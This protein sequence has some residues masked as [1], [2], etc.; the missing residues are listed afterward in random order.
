MVV[1][2]ALARV[3][4]TRVTV[5]DA[6]WA[7]RIRANRERTIPFEYEQCRI[8]G[9]IDALRLAWKPGD[10][11]V[12]HIFWES[13]VA[14]WIE[15]ASYSLAT[16]PDAKLDA[17][18]DEVIVLLAGAQGPD[19]Y[20]NVHFT[21]VEPE[22]RF[23]NLRDWHELYCAGHLI[24]AAVAHFEATGKRSLLD[25]LCRYADY[26]ATV[27]GPGE[28]QRR[29]Y[30]GH[31]E[32][33]LALVKLYRATGERRYLDLAKFFVDERGDQ[34]H[35][36]DAEREARGAGGVN[37]D[38][39]DRHYV[40]PGG[41]WTYEYNQAH[42]PLREQD[43]VVGHS[44][45]AMYIYSAMADLAGE[46]GDESLVRACERLW[47]HLTG[48]LMYVTGGIGSSAFNEG[49]TADFDMPNESAYCETCA[50]IGLVFWA[51]RLLHLD[52]DGRYA[53]V[54]ERALYNG[55]VSGVSLDGERFFYE[56]PLESVGKHRRQEWFDCAC[57]PPNIAR[58]LASLS[59]Y[60]YSE[61][62]SEA[63]VH[64]YVQGEAK[65]NVAGGSLTLRQTTEYPWNGRVNVAVEPSAP[66]R[67]ALKLRI[68]GWCRQASISVNG[69]VVPFVAER[70][71][72]R[73]EREWRAGDVVTLDLAMPVERVH[74]DPR[75]RADVG[76]VALQRGP[77]IYCLEAVDN[78]A[79]L[80][81]LALPRD[82]KLS[83]E[84][85]SDLLG[86]VAVIA[87]QAL[88]TEWSGDV[89]SAS[90]GEQVAVPFTAVPYCVWENREPGEMLV[91]V[92]E[93]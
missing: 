14:K 51:S 91:W 87:G 39:G 83:V 53:D 69:E 77:I 8:T 70:G 28:G 19:G 61:S 26:V 30:C 65:L 93:A 3:P 25:V 44:V 45:R 29:G 32:I 52:C 92:R 22:K 23:T 62:A 24:E 68:P 15:A 17:L 63:V 21:V 55:V 76:R 85:M 27:F 49:F 10:Q 50:S 86:G 16:H 37:E 35:Y 84:V 75:V 58:L 74:A 12:P 59:G 73:I 31:P 1:K 64:L 81:A 42:R 33:E 47:Q 48:S 82:A 36:Y 67:F 66:A 9:R 13:D 11:P 89:Y 60:V 18:L 78:G 38:R 71:Y 54:L 56:N 72:A 5:D 2:M 46:Y 80:N 6:F 7:P 4:F 90:P 40:R 20:L 79:G 88:K 57:C 43:R 34:P 41:G